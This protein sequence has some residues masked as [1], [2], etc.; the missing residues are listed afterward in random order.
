MT[1]Y[2]EFSQRVFK[3]TCLDSDMFSL[4]QI[5]RNFEIGFSEHFRSFTLNKF[6]SIFV[7]HSHFGFKTEFSKN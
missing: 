4:N 5:G 7:N 2:S 6:H 3:L 1:N